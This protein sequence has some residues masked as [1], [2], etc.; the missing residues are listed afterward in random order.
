[1]IRYLS[2]FYATEFAPKLDSVRVPVLVLIPEFTPAV[3]ADRRTP[4]LKTFFKDSWEPA[5]SRPNVQ[6]R[7][8]PNAAVNVWL[9]QPDAFRSILKE[10]AAR[11]R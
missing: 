4:Y 3:L 9:D 10:F 5:R 2:D 8:V 6:T 11:A 1:M 7:A